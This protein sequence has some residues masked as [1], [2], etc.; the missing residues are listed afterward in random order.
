MHKERWALDGWKVQAV[1]RWTPTLCNFK[2]QLL[3][4]DVYVKTFY[5]WKVINVAASMRTRHRKESLCSGSV[6]YGLKQKCNG[7]STC[8]LY[9]VPKHR[10]Y[11][12]KRSGTL[13]DCLEI[14]KELM[15]RFF[16]KSFKEVVNEFFLEIIQCFLTNFSWHSSKI[17]VCLFV[18]EILM[19]IF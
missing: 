5:L 18:L 1:L 4:W 14:R 12:K 11:C 16:Q 6:K 3:I 10:L 8:R 17:S 19:D 7:S 13:L 15:Q 9:E 2:N